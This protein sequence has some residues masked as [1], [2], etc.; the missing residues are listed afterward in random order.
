V[1]RI[2]TRQR[3]ERRTALRTSRSAEIM[4]RIFWSSFASVDRFAPAR[5]RSTRRPE[6]PQQ[7]TRRQVFPSREYALEFRA[8][9]SPKTPRDDAATLMVVSRLLSALKMYPVNLK[10]QC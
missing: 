6:R 5:S 10:P 9:P 3:M 4:S 7:T 2:T 8:V 1:G